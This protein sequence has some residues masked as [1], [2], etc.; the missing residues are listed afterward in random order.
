M[1][2]DDPRVG[3]LSD[4]AGPQPASPTR[5]SKLMGSIKRGQTKNCDRSDGHMYSGLS[6]DAGNDSVS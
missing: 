4:E 6:V 5:N 2:A 1:L 3:A